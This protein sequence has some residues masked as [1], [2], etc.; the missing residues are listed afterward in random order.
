MNTPRKCIARDFVPK[1]FYI[2]E[3]NG[4]EQRYV[5]SFSDIAGIKRLLWYFIEA[6][7]DYLQVRIADLEDRDSPIDYDGASSKENLKLVIEKY[8][9]FVFHDGYHDFMLRHP[10]SGDYI[11]YDEHDNIYIYSNED[12]APVLEGIGIEHQIDEQFIFNV[13]HYHYRSGSGK[14]MFRNLVIDME[15][16]ARF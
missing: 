11:A 13:D 9:D 6:A 12:Y 4:E 3:T 10:K 2:I 16:V 1:S 14:E 5:V 7:E 8:S 15:L